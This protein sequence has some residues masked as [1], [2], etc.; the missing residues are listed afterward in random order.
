MSGAGADPEGE[1]Q[2]MRHHL[3]VLYR[4]Y[5]DAILAGRKSIECR[6]AK[7]GNIP[8]GLVEPGDL[9]W[10]KESC[11]P[12][13]AVCGVR[14]V[15]CFDRLTPARVD[16]L[17]RRFNAGIGA[18]GAF[19]R[20]HRYARVATLIWLDNVCA[21]EPFVVKKSDRRAWVVLAAPPVPGEALVSAVD[22]LV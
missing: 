12:I 6:L 5:F 21:L 11:G 2:S 1:K 4:V 20:Q 18:P 8:H 7:M 9:I 22:G 14:M 3:A 16:W 13:R 15:R 10:L 17:C 19:W